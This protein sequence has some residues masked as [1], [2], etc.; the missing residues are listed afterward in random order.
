MT[1]AQA[2][3]SDLLHVLSV[4][5]LGQGHTPLPGGSREGAFWLGPVYPVDPS[6]FAFIP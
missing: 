4:V 2:L 6:I 1:P 5:D 3:F